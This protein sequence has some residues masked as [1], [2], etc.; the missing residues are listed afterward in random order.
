MKDIGRGSPE[1]IVLVIS[2]PSDSNQS[3]CDLGHQLSHSNFFDYWMIKI[4]KATA[5]MFQEK[6]A[7]ITGASTGVCCALAQALAERG[8]DVI[9]TARTTRGL[10]A[11]NRKQR[12]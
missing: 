3:I 9:V 11:R 10:S 4:K 7:L 12:G 8:A 6:V 1:G 5:I 2:W